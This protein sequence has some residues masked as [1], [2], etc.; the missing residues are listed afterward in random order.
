MV[1]FTIALSVEEKVSYGA[2]KYWTSVR[3]GLKLRSTHDTPMPTYIGMKKKYRSN[4]HVLLMFWSCVDDIIQCGMG[5]K[6]K[7]V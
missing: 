2:D 1:Y 6:N 4:N 3:V 5:S 7:W